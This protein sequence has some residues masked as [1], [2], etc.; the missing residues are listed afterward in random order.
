MNRHCAD[1]SFRSNLAIF[2]RE[3]LISKLND[4]IRKH[5]TTETAVLFQRRLQLEMVSRSF[6]ITALAAIFVVIIMLLVIWYE[7][8]RYL[9]TIFEVTSAF[10]TVGL[11]KG[12]WN[13][14]KKKA[15]RERG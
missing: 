4:F 8:T 3:L 14:N 9:S 10:G 5:R 12:K 13:R 15:L 11:S 2:N 1:Y 6:L 7:D